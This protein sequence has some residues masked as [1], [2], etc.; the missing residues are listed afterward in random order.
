MFPAPEEKAYDR[1]IERAL[2][3]KNRG[4]YIKFRIIC[5]PSIFFTS[6]F[7]FGSDPNTD[8]T[9]G[10]YYT[11]IGGLGSQLGSHLD[12]C[13]GFVCF[14]SSGKES[15]TLAFFGTTKPLLS[16]FV[17]GRLLVSHK[18][19]TWEGRMLYQIFPCSISEWEC[20]ISK[21]KKWFHTHYIMFLKRLTT[22]A[23]VLLK[24]SK[25]RDAVKYYYNLTRSLF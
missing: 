2:K 24:Y 10:F 21:D 3:E 15:E 13:C 14:C 16:F 5:S 4:A 19:S 25:N 1:T 22:A 23:V 12:N 6:F 18:N 20:L 7:K 8:S 17:D 11:S 9:G